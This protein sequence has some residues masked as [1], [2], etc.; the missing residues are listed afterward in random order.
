MRFFTRQWFDL[1][2]ESGTDEDLRVDEPPKSYLKLLQT[3]N[4]PAQILDRLD[5]HDSEVMKIHADSERMV[6]ELEE[7][8]WGY[9][10]VNFEKPEILKMDTGI[11]GCEWLY[12]EIYRENGGYEMH[13]L[14][15]SRKE[16]GLKELILRCREIM[17]D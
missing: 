1:L 6:L 2:Q 15:Y 7:R 3:Q 17:I 11:L 10:H 4:I 8:E 12:E 5:F 14:F 9:S 13:V 16:L